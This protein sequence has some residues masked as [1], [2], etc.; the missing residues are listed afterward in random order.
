MYLRYWRAPI[1]SLGISPL[2]TTSHVNGRA[3]TSTMEV[4]GGTAGILGDPRNQQQ[5]RDLPD[6]V[7][8]SCRV[9][10]SSILEG[11]RG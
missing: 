1:D 10:K 7:K 8:I 4:S 9:G 2:E 5:G 11:G 3:A 6:Y